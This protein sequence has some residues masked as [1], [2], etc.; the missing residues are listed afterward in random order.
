[1]DGFRFDLASILGRDIWGAPLANPPLLEALAHDPILAKCKLIAEAWDA[2]GLYQVG[3][4]PSYGRWAEWNGRYRDTVRRFLKGD[5]GVVGDMAERLAGSSDLYYGRGT[6]ASINF[7]TCH[8]GFNLADL[9]SYND[10]HNE[11]NGEENRDGA[12]DN[13]SWN[14]GAEGPTDD[15]GVNALRRRQMKNALAMLLVSQGV[16]MLLMG[17]EVGR[18]QQGNNNVYCQDNG[19]NWLDWSLREKNADL[20]RFTQRLIAFRQAHRVLRR[21]THFNAQSAGPHGLP[22]ISWHGTRAWDADWSGT[23]RT[24]AFMLT[25]SHEPTQYEDNSIYV[26]LNMHWDTHGFA[27]PEPPHGQRW[28]VFV[29]TDMP[30]PQDV[31]E[32]G[33]EP[34]L[35]EQAFVLAAGRSVVILVGKRTAP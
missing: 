8:D 23:G 27:L 1:I 15:P 21:A 35:E 34:L 33:N 32:P 4:F 3:S 2:G 17:D 30:S 22:E 29:N 19:L 12:N 24:L 6:T 31:W 25:G 11:A 28:H 18:T 20:F 10:K 16:P 26:I 13:H 14:C 7:I 5:L 9:V